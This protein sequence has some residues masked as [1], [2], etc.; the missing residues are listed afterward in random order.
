[1]DRTANGYEGL[2]AELKRTRP[3]G[4]FCGWYHSHPFEPEAHGDHCW[5]SGIDVM[6]QTTQQ[7]VYENDG[8]P[9]VGLVVD[10]QTSL[11]DGT[12]HFGAFRCY[13]RGYDIESGSVEDGN[14]KLKSPL[15]ADLIH[16]RAHKLQSVLCPDGVERSESDSGA[17]WGGQWNRYYK[18]EI[19]FFQSAMATMIMSSLKKN[20][21]WVDALAVTPAK[22]VAYREEFPQRVKSLNSSLKEMTTRFSRSSFGL[23]ASGLSDRFDDPPGGGSG[24]KKKNEDGQAGSSNPATESMN[25]SRNLATQLVTSTMGSVGKL[26]AMSAD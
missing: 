20:F 8:H 17:A 22:T 12:P 16:N 1:M 19:E 7:Q 25:V 11:K 15:P 5:F 23:A 18:L 21:L 6:T 14:V 4:R 9:F 10:P 26:M 13:D 2:Q 24:S 3:E